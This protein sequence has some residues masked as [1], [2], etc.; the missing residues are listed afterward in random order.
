MSSD[1]KFTVEPQGVGWLVR[2]EGQGDWKAFFEVVLKILHQVQGTPC[3]RVLFDVRPLAM[4]LNTIDRYELATAAAQQWDR[5]LGAGMLVPA[6]L[7]DTSRFGQNVA[8]N[9]GL[10]VEIFEEERAALR[11]LTKESEEPG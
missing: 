6:S 8:R 3:Q 1:V 5:R 11:W 2:V 10:S 4:S 7:L 9:R